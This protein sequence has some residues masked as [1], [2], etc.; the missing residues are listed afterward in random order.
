MLPNRVNHS[1]S[2]NM[3]IPAPHA[4]HASSS[5][6]SSA[7]TTPPIAYSSTAP[8]IIADSTPFLTRLR[9]GRA[10]VAKN[11]VPNR[12]AATS[13]LNTPATNVTG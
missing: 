7:A 12:T 11:T 3:A 5:S 10:K 4:T 13:A 8:A 6:C 9:G 2:E 1:A